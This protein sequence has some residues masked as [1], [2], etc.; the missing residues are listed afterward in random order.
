VVIRAPSPGGPGRT[1]GHSL[2]ELLVSLLVLALTL[3]AASTTALLGVR[4]SAEGAAR[5]AAVRHAAGVLD[6][7]RLRAAPPGPGRDSTSIVSVAWDVLPRAGGVNIRVRAAARN[8]SGPPFEL[9]G[10]WVPPFPVLPDSAGG[11]P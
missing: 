9:R 2:V 4:R 6:S 1:A 5:Q 3:G 10:L 8:A 11:G 7:L